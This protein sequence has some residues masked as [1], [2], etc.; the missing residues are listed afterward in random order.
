[1]FSASEKRYKTYNLIS[2]L[3]G[4]QTKPGIKTNI[5]IKT[6]AMAIIFHMPPFLPMC[7]QWLRCYRSY[8]ADI[9]LMNFHLLS[10]WTSINLILFK[11]YAKNVPAR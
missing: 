6:L 4:G 5:F 8:R 7:L 11:K 3:S 9:I 1:M 10:V 2:F